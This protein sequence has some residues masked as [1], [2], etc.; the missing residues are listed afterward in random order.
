[1]PQLEAKLVTIIT[2]FD[3]EHRVREALREIGIRGFSVARVDG[4]GVH[5]E[6]QGGFITHESA[7]FTVVTTA[8]LAAKI[9]AWVEQH[10]VPTSPGIAYVTDVVAVLQPS[11]GKE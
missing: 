10:F 3:A 2:T 7:A 1:M 5:G 6:R 8:E 11:P 4:E 9:M